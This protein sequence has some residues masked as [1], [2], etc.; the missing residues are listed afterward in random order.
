MEQTTNKF[1]NVQPWEAKEFLQQLDEKLT[2]KDEI[3]VDLD[4]RVWE[5]KE[6]LAKAQEDTSKI[7]NKFTTLKESIFS[8]LDNN[9]EGDEIEI[10]LDEANDF[11]YANGIQ[12]IKTTYSVHFTIT[13]VL[14]IEASN[15]DEAEREAS[16]VDVSHHMGEITEFD[17]TIDSVEQE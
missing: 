2:I 15:E 10:T 1:D 11:L 5:L 12:T 6:S 16:D 4:K 3:I 17:V 13:G 9:R 7:F 14:E 8:L